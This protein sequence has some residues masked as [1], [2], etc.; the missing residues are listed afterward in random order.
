MEKKIKVYTGSRN[1]DLGTADNFGLGITNDNIADTLFFELD[2]MIEGQASLL[3]DLVGEDGILAPLPLEKKENG[4]ELIVTKDI[5]T[6]SE[7]TIQL[8]IVNGEYVWHSKDYTLRI[9]P[10]LEAGQGEMPSG[11]T[12]WLN[13]ADNK[14]LEV[15]NAIAEARE[16][17]NEIKEKADSGF[18]N[19]KDG[20]TPIKGVDY[21]DG[22]T[23]PQGIQGPRGE[24]GDTGER[25]PQGI[26]GPI[27][28]TGAKG[29]R[30]LQGIQGIKGDTGSQGPKGNDGATPNIQIG[31]VTTLESNKQA[32][33]TRKGT[34]ANPIFDFGIPKGADGQG[35][36]GSTYTAGD[37]IKIEDNVISVEVSDSSSS[38]NLYGAT[39]EN[40]VATLFYIM[41]YFS[42]S[43][44]IS[45]LLNSDNWEVHTK[46]T[47]L[48]PLDYF[49]TIFSVGKAPMEGG[50]WQGF[51]VGYEEGNTA[52]FL[53]NGYYWGI[54]AGRVDVP[55]SMEYGETYEWSLKCELDEW[56]MYVY[57]LRAKNIKD[58]D[59][60]ELC[61][62]VHHYQVSV[63]IEPRQAKIIFGQNNAS[64][65]YGQSYQ[66]YADY[67]L[68]DTWYKINDEIAWS[69]VPR[70]KKLGLN[71]YVENKTQKVQNDVTNYVDSQIEMVG[72]YI[73]NEIGDMGTIL[74]TLTDV[75]GDE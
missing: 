61:Q 58:S 16:T 66:I 57:T 21:F 60:T 68:E 32:Y 25:G 54:H 69:A 46:L 11:I 6:Q 13:E 52:L 33:V 51:S 2:K 12:V 18:F 3:T 9:L 1:M 47:F 73:V 27:G 63:S 39:V 28:Q 36:G 45:E 4:Y 59:Y 56:G 24:K 49:Y 42:T 43:E 30:G 70:P 74:S 15:N 29:D 72:Q 75:G 23:G 17:A 35:G 65:I 20:Y 10:V 34:D 22:V 64:L 31:T 19:G 8:Q 62:A 14:L 38:L 5:L 48:G 26:Q 44:D 71:E 40:N 67:Y 7:L 50:D 55:F 41:D 37:S 53:G